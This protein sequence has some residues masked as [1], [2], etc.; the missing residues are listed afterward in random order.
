MNVLDYL[1]IVVRRG[2]IILLAMLL[3]AGGAFVFSRLQTPIYRGTQ[4]ILV[5]P[6]RPDFGLQQTMR[7]LMASYVARL[8][9]EDR[10]AEVIDQLKL[11]MLPAQIKGV[12]TASADLSTYV[13]S[14]DVDLSDGESAKQI[15][16]QYGINFI[17]WRNQENAPQRQED[18]IN[19]ELLGAGSFGL[20]RPNTTI[21]VLA[22]ALLGL[23]FGGVVVFVLEYLE[24][25]IL[26][27]REDVERFLS[28][29]VLG[30]LPEVE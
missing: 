12:T 5:K 17:E 7:Q 11:D 3:T 10:S 2:W 22:G 23:I 18:R 28:L 20:Y 13:V 30:S 24:S 26:R 21:N 4:Q 16:R 1:R 14:I 27:R 15:A 9:V 25:N 6:A 29:P 8:N 19:A